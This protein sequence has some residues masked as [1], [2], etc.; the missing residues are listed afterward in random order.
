MSLKR[1]YITTILRAFVLSPLMTTGVVVAA[2]FFGA[3]ASLIPV[4]IGITVIIVFYYWVRFTLKT[5]L[6]DK[7]SH[8]LMPFLIPYFYMMTIWI[9]IF[10]MN[11]YSF[12]GGGYF[13]LF[14]L[15]MPYFAANFIFGLMSD[16]T[17]FPVVITGKT[18]FML[19]AVLGTLIYKKK[20]LRFDKILACGVSAV[21]VLSATAGFQQYSRTQK[22]ITGNART[23]RVNAEVDMRQYQPFTHNNR[24]TIMPWEPDITIT[25]NYPILDG[26]TA[27]Y[28]VF[29]AIAQEL[30]KGIGEYNITRYVSVSTTDAAYER[31]LNGEIDIFFGAQPSE[32]QKAA[33][34]ERGVEFV[35]TPIALEAFV[36]FVHAD[37]PVSNLTVEQIQ[38]IYQKNITNWRHLGGSRGRIIPFQRAEGSGS[39]TIMESAVM[40]GKPLATPLID[41]RVDMMG[42]IVQQVADYRNFASAIGYSFRY[43]VTD[44]KTDADIKLL[45]INGTAPTAENIR[46]GTYPFTV[47]VYAVTAGSSN[48]NTAVLINWILSQQGQQFLELCGVVPIYG[49]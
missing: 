45:S 2:L 19:V 7:L 41:E 37:N 6:P 27:A 4:F 16:W 34:R 40:R 22:F 29:A 28:P 10:G 35:L 33:A 39:Q 43:F 47:N 5:E 26:A 17:W 31:L 36:F 46:N 30:Y 24:L 23:Q 11:K 21:L 20:K 38:D 49:H 3:Y 12:I 42:G 14:I 13:L 25:D 32:M 8:T 18:A 9:I 15:A 1:Y 44:M 48:P